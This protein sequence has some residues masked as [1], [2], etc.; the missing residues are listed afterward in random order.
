MPEIRIV[1]VLLNQL[2]TYLPLASVIKPK[3]KEILRARSRGQIKSSDIFPIVAIRSNEID[4][5]IEPV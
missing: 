1:G 4:Y 5:R 2:G 3:S